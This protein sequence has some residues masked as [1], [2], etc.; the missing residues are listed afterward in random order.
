VGTLAELKG[1]ALALVL[2]VVAVPIAIHYD[3]PSSCFLLAAMSSC[4]FGG[5]K[6]GILAVVVLALAFSF[7]FLPPKHHLELASES[8]VRFIA[9]VGS[10]LLATELTHA[11][12][13]SDSARLERDKEFR[14]M[15]ETC[16]D[17]ILFVDANQI[18]Q[19]AN[20][21]TVA[22]FGYS[23]EEVLG[24]SPSFLIEGLDSVQEPVGEFTART[25]QRDTIDVD[26]TC[27]RFGNKTTIFLRDISDRKHAQ[28]ELAH[29]EET[30]RLT[31]DTIPVMAYT[32]SADGNVD[33]A[34]RHASEYFGN[35]VQQLRDGAWIESL[36]PEERDFVLGRIHESS[37]TEQGYVMEYRRKGFDG[38]YRW[39]QTRVEPLKDSDGR[40]IRWY[41]IL[42]DIDDRRRIEDMLRQTE[43]KLS[44]AA[45][46][47]TAA[48]LSAS[49]VHE[50]SQPIAA[51][52]TNGQ[53]CVRWLNASPPN[54]ANG[55][56][57]AERIVRDGKDAREIIKG[58]RTLFKRSA[59]QK[60]ALSVREIADEVVLLKRSQL[61]REGTSLD[62]LIPRDLPMILGDRTQIQQVLL[63]LVSNALDAVRAN[64][65]RPKAL[66][67]RSTACDGSVMV[68]V[69]DNGEG[70]ADAGR[71]FE[72]FYTTKGD[73]MGMG[74]SISK[75]IIEA[76]GGRLWALN[77]K[78]CGA[79]FSFSLPCTDATF[80]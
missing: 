60:T 16:P 79:V 17:C 61:Q 13:R 1:Y 47:A 9:F 19:F 5:R 53:A 23:V 55:V 15:A 46:M 31:L 49:I 28:R 80:N 29:S 24:K 42:I 73:G 39:F 56:M 75:S 21:A 59:P 14:I 50:I 76:H 74:L 25:K 48:E 78:P 7:F 27:G 66:T 30:L 72:T 2:C 8:L 18:I 77:A 22:I 3:I 43:V 34:N 10:M 58:L 54:L 45:Q 65:D 67:V 33:Y 63:N 6:P 44:R 57:A 12:L 20:P 69:M 4:L 36:H 71:V 64:A 35:T 40:L 38:V 11:R 32:R 51:M 70:L 52:V 26:A 68:E 41:G 62:V 37:A